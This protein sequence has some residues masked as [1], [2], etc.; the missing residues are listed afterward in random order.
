MVS[1]ATKTSPLI[2]YAVAPVCEAIL[3]GK[4]ADFV[5]M[6]SQWKWESFS[7]LLP[8]HILLKIAF[9]QTPRPERGQDQIYYS[10]SNTG[11]FTVRSAYH[12][13]EGSRHEDKE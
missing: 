1:W 6:D 12:Y 7:S 10:A 11:D 9:I 3:H 13:L 2:D 8:N 5:N 4:V